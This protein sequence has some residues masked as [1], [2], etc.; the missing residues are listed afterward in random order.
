MIFPEH[1][2]IFFHVPRTGGTSVEQMLA[3]G[4]LDASVMDRERLW[5]M[6]RE[7]GFN[8]HH[9]TCA[10]TLQLIGRERFDAWYKFAVVRD[11]FFRMVSF[12]YYNFNDYRRRFGDFKGYLQALPDLMARRGNKQGHHETPQ[13]DFTHVDGQQVV[14][15]ILR[16]EALPGC[17]DA[18]RERL[19][20][21]EALPDVNK[22]RYP[23]VRRKPTAAHYDA[24]TVDLVRRAYAD[25]FA[26]FGYP[27]TLDLSVA[28]SQGRGGEP[29]GS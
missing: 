11:P 20:V 13:R 6:D 17:I 19:G 16:F 21:T 5:G 8:L 15:T 26:L 28:R 27:D 14:D 4:P 24:E 25:D 2:T 1:R 3:K 29:A 9:A 18:V 7:A 12:Y 22:T 23:S 10:T